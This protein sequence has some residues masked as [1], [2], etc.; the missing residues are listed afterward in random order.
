MKKICGDNFPLVLKK[1]TVRAGKGKARGRKYKSNAGLLIITGKDEKAK[2]RGL[3]VVPLNE[4]TIA[5]FYPLGRLTLYTKTAL[6]EL[7]GEE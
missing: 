5:D 2:F 7:G 3:D 4:V 6:D 1:K